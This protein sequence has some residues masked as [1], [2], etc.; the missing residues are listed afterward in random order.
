MTTIRKEST[1]EQSRTARTR[2]LL[3]ELGCEEL[4]QAHL[5][6]VGVGGVGGTAVELL[7]RSGVGAFTLVDADTVDPSNINRQA[8]AFCSTVGKNKVDVM[9]KMILDINPNAIVHKQFLFVSP[10]NVC[11]LFDTTSTPFSMVIDAIDTLTPKC[12][13][14][15]ET[16]KRGIPLISS[17]GAGA[18]TDPEAVHIA[19][20]HKTHTC[21]LAK[22]VRQH[23][24]SVGCR[25]P[26][27]CVFSTQLAIEAAILPQS[28]K[29][30]KKSV[31]GTISYMPQLFGLRIAAY[32]IKT[33]T[34]S[35]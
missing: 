6:V 10:D 26:F 4:K 25:E 5:L 20:I 15:Q 22:A 29:G 1:D 11:E 31:V 34:Q 13:L 21:G 14:I 28:D 23:L 33:L 3:G 24:R 2:I 17:M 12:A 27:P 9:E 8:V 30:G 16:L 18:K 19:P 32:V 7:A 35:L